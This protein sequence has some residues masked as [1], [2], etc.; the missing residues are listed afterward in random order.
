MTVPSSFV[1]I[2][3]GHEN[4]I[5][6]GPWSSGVSR[7]MHRVG[8]EIEFEISSGAGSLRLTIAIFILDDEGC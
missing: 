6:A 7:S 5:N 4:I 8:T 1:V 2:C 3:P